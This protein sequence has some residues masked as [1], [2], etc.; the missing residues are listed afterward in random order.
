MI[1]KQ[2]R[3]SSFNKKTGSVPVLSTN[4]PVLHRHLIKL[5]SSNGNDW[6]SFPEESADKVGKIATEWAEQ[7]MRFEKEQ[8]RHV[9]FQRSI[10]AKFAAEENPPPMNILNDWLVKKKIHK[11]C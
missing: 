11:M 10:K 2:K 9:D 4:F 3:W 5:T 8:E 6:Q 1:E 7:I